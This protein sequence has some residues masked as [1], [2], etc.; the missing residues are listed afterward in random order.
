MIKHDT[1][2]IAKVITNRDA[3]SLPKVIEI[4]K[5]S[6]VLSYVFDLIHRREN[7]LSLTAMTMHETSF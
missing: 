7:N 6:Y 3:F 1:F 5:V 4:S 2:A